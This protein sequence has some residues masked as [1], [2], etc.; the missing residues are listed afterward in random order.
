MAFLC[1]LRAELRYCIEIGEIGP[2][3][4]IQVGLEAVG[5]E[6]EGGMKECL[7][8]DDWGG[9]MIVKEEGVEKLC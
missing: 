5:A 7:P 8:V 6:C 1:L 3:R 4:V 2:S 9:G